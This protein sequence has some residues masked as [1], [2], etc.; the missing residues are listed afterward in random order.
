MVF[1]IEIRLAK[2]AHNKNYSFNDHF[3]AS[4]TEG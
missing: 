3:D 1:N 2:Q 4:K